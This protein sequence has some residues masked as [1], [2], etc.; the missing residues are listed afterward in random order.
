MDDQLA[1][2]TRGAIDVIDIADL[3]RK[4]VRGRP[5]IVKLGADPTAPDLHLGHT[6][7]LDVLRRF[8]ALGH[9]VQFLIGDF[10][11]AIGDPTGRS[12]TRP[13]LS[14]EQIEAAAATYTAQVSLVL[15]ADVEIVFNSTWFAKMPVTDFITLASKWTLAR[16]LERADFAERFADHEAIHMHELLYP[17]VQGFDSVAMRADVELGGSD[18]RFN[19]LVGRGLQRDYGQEPQ[20]IV[21][22][23]LLVGLDGVDKMSKSKGNAIGVTESPTYQV[24]KTMSISD[25]TMRQ[26]C[27]LL[28][29]AA[30]DAPPRLQK[31]ALARSIVTRFHGHAAAAAAIDEYERKAA[32]GAPDAMPEITL[33][34]GTSLVQALVGSQL[35]PSRTRALR[36]LANH[37]IVVDGARATEDRVLGPGP[38][39]LRSGKNRF[40][41][42]IV[43]D[44]FVGPGA[45]SR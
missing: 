37:A 5:L 28:G 31:L 1:E 26:W 30:P 10:T 36:D 44:L 38:H 9:R 20:A 24:T 17:L 12:T 15:N 4:L 27:E 8:H 29:F 18:Q 39:V 2:L 23:P 45:R 21:M 22:M 35:A 6:V 14:R 11:G 34:T 32:G 19:L 25:A 33:P 3:R 43:Q 7:V 13:H 40:A 42:V 41:R 16:M